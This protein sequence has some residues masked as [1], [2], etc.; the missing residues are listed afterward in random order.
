[1]FEG[2]SVEALAGRLVRLLEAAVAA[3]EVAIGRLDILSAAERHTILQ[4]WNATERA[5]PGATLPQLFAAQA[6]ETPDAV[7]VVFE[8]EQLS[9][10]E[11][12]AR[13]NQLAHH[14]RARGVGAE[15]VVGVC[16]ERS[17]ELG[18]ALIA[19]LKAGGAYLPLDP[20]YPRERLNFMLAD[21]AAA[22]LL[23]QSGLRER[24]DA[25][26]VRRLELDGEAAAIAAHP[27]SAPASTVGPHNLAYVIYTSGSTGTP[28]GVAV[29]HGGLS[30]VL[31]AMQE[32]VLIGRHDRLMAVT[33]IG[34]DIAALE[35]FLPLINGAGLA[36]APGEIVKDPPALACT[37]EKTGSTILQGTPTLWHALTPRAHSGK[38]SRRTAPKDCRVSR[39]WSAASPSR[40]GS[41]LPC[42]GSGVRSRISMDRQRLRSGQRSWLSMTMTR[43]HR[44]LV[45]RF[46]TR[47]FMYWTVVWGLCLLVLVGS[48]TSRGLGLGGAML[49]VAG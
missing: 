9:Y 26:G 19:I 45:V 23:T 38:R 2:A 15:S 42:A 17:L 43:K 21:A 28:K 34:F 14:L 10:G 25:P 49:V 35:L 47:G 29:T 41:P 3:P 11:L 30:N 24:V 8:G 37:I 31:L 5:L 13:A 1:L 18:V 32:Q 44:R 6:C 39:C 33:T 7:A 16:L 46:G 12:E 48:F 27:Q 40:T 22:V 36:I 20:G 4:E